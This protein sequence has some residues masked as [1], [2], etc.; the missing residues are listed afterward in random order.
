MNDGSVLLNAWNTPLKIVAPNFRAFMQ[1]MQHSAGPEMQSLLSAIP[2]RQFKQ[3]GAAAQGIAYFFNLFQVDPK[4][5]AKQPIM[6]P[7]PRLSAQRAMTLL[8]V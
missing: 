2:M 7:F 5:D 3:F 4:P 6:L 8:Q 1:N